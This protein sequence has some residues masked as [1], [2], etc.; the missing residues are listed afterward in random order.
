MG[1]NLVDTQYTKASTNHEWT[2]IHGCIEGNSDLYTV[3]VCVWV[4]L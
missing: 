4:W 2:T 3:C 1:G